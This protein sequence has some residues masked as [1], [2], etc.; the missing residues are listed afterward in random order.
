MCVFIN[1]S[2]FPRARI[3]INKRSHEPWRERDHRL[4]CR[5]RTGDRPD[6][7]RQ[8][9]QPGRAGA[10]RHRRARGF[11]VRTA[12]FEQFVRESLEAR[13]AGAR[14]GWKRSRRTTW[15]AITALSRDTAPARRGVAD[16]GR[17]RAAILA[18]H[19]ELCAVAA[20]GSAPVAVRSS[21]TTEDAED[22]SFAGLQDTYLWVHGADDSARRRAA[23]LGQPVFGGVHQLPAAAGHRRGRRGDGRRRPAHGGCPHGRRHVHAQPDSPATAR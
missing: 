2:T 4:V 13:G 19:A 3:P 1:H 20:N 6:G 11:V 9:R 16:A 10:R 23:L 8:G 22:A 17:C 14:P 15:T 12:A 18:A 21:A 7:G 5:H